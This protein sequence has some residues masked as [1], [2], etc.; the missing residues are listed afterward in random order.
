M[1]DWEPTAERGGVWLVKINTV[2]IDP[3][4]LDWTPDRVTIRA[5]RFSRKRVASISAYPSCASRI[6]RLE[7]SKRKRVVSVSRRQRSGRLRNDKSDVTAD[8]FSSTK[9]TDSFRA[10][11]RRYPVRRNGVLRRARRTAYRTNERCSLRA[12]LL[13]QMRLETKP[14]AFARRTRSAGAKG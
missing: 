10:R 4:C 2:T 13:T 12:Q 6:L 3:F 1:S 9:Q 11:A 5:C 7:F 8:R 14:S